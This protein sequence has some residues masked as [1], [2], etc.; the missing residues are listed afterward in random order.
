[1]RND[2]DRNKRDQLAKL[3]E[4]E[5]KK[6]RFRAPPAFDWVCCTHIHHAPAHAPHTHPHNV[7]PAASRSRSTAASASCGVATPGQHTRTGLFP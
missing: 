2:P 6:V 5:A 4:E 1:M 7:T 3:A